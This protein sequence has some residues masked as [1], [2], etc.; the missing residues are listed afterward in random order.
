MHA[1]RS[2]KTPSQTALDKCFLYRDTILLGE[3]HVVYTQ[4]A[5]GN[6]CVKVWLFIQCALKPIS[7]LKK[8]RGERQPFKLGLVVGKHTRLELKCF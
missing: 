6:L 3:L 4:L 2:K 7:T 1:S 5:L 8:K